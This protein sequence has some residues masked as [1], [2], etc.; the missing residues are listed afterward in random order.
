M[1]NY[2]KII[3]F[4][5]IVLCCE[6]ALCTTKAGEYLPKTLPTSALHDLNGREF[7]LGRLEGNVLL[8]H[9]WATWCASCTEEL[10]TLN[11]LQK[12]LRKDP[13]IVIPISEDFKGAEVVRSFYNKNNLKFLPAFL[14]KNNKWFREMK[15]S[16]LPTTFI[17]DSQGRNVMLMS[18]KVD[19]LDEANISL[20]KKYT[21]V[22]Q[23]YNQDYVSLL[24][25]H[26]IVVDK[27]K[28]TK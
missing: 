2:T 23:P 11:K 4:C 16:S 21:S 12:L 26:K 5:S 9:F 25:E 27:P 7:T 17:I 24:N 6:H 14:D 28:S 15:V 3:I 13:V 22:K 8:V 19:W 10:K 1:L 18:E 20:I